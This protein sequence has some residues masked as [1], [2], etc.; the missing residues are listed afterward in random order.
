MVR[1]LRTAMGL[2]RR[3]HSRIFFVLFIS[4]LLIFM[5]TANSN[6]V[7]FQSSELDTSNSKLVSKSYDIERISFSVDDSSPD[8]YNFFIHFVSAISNALFADRTSFASVLIDIN[9]DGQEDYSIDTNYDRVYIGTQFHEARLVD[10]RDSKS[11]LIENC[12]TQ[13]WTDLNRKVSWIGFRTKKNCIPFGTSFSLI[14]YSDFKSGDNLDYDYAPEFWWTVTPGQPEKRISTECKK[15]DF[16]TL[17]NSG[18]YPGWTW[19]TGGVAKTVTWAAVDAPVGKTPP[20]IAGEK[21][22]RSLTNN[23]KAWLRVAFNS[24]D[25]ASEALTFSEVDVLNN[26]K[27]LVGIVDSGYG[28]SLYAITSEG[29]LSEAWIKLDGKDSR[30]SERDS[31]ISMAQ[32][33]I[34]NILNL[35][36]LKASSDFESVMETPVQAPF[37]RATL[38]NFDI[39]LIRQLNG[40]S[41]C[42]GSWGPELSIAVAE[43]RNVE[44]KAKAEAELMNKKQ[45]ITCIKGRTTKKVTGVKPKCPT[46]YVKR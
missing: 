11:N 34:G 45:T 9:A 33:Y 13:T 21:T 2:D 7:E 46:G 29:P 18:F 30:L 3:S 40:E 6:W 26:P 16:D 8:F 23:Q 17:F 36:D 22:S 25:L 42:E 31:F 32:S 5:P 14:G 1:E 37:G 38:S 28:W 15:F 12:T 4:S 39:A 10:R 43:R 20:T 35:G 27:I 19:T 24:W 41:T 44:A